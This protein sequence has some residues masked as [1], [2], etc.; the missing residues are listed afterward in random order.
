MWLRHSRLRFQLA[1]ERFIH[2]ECDFDAY[3]CAYDTHEC[4]YNTQECEFNTQKIESARC[5]ATHNFFLFRH[6]LR[7]TYR[8]NTKIITVYYKYSMDKKFT[9]YW[10]KFKIGSLYAAVEAYF[11]TD[12]LE[13][14]GHVNQKYKKMLCFLRLVLQSC[15]EF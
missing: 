8:I 3:E 10:I 6:A 7:Y 9:D 12:L 14:E 2:A 13:E 11:L 4:D 5:V 15:V 1:Q